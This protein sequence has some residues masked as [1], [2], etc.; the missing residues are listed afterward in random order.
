MVFAV[1]RRDAAG[2]LVLPFQGESITVGYQDVVPTRQKNEHSLAATL[3][4]VFDCP[5]P[6]GCGSDLLLRL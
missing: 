5:Q 2:W 1:T 4:L 6:S 3:K